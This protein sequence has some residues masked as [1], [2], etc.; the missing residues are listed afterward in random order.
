MK[1]AII[2]D[3]HSNL[4]AL[5]AVSR[6]IEIECVDQIWCL[7]DIVGYGAYPNEC[8]KWVEENASKT[9]L[10]N[11]ELGVLSMADLDQFNP[12]ARE[13]IVWTKKTLSDESVD[14]LSS[15]SLQAFTDNCQ[16]V[17]DTPD[18]PGSMVYITDE[19]LAYK[20]LISQKRRICFFGHT[21]IPATF[22]LT[23]AGAET[24]KNRTLLALSGR[25]LINPGSVGQPRDRNP[26]ASYIIFDGERVSF[27][28]VPYDTK[29]AAKSIIEAGLPEF[30]AARLLV[31]V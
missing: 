25:Y 16:L 20:A 18:N 5:K 17:H 27:K 11:H 19:R 13:T 1:I 22:K 8:I 24:I 29:K 10:G 4:D 9:V 7:G 30:L 14:F 15:L 26:D 21:H 6:D 31:G 23:S 3:I 28:R 2:S 12:Y